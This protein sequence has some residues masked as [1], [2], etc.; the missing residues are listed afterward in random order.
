MTRKL[1][2]AVRPIT[3]PPCNFGSCCERRR[4]YST[5]PSGSNVQ[6]A[7]SV[8]Y[9][10]LRRFLVTDIGDA[11]VTLAVVV[12]TKDLASNQNYQ[13]RLRCI[14]VTES[15]SPDFFGYHGPVWK[16]ILQHASS[17]KT[18]SQTVCVC[19]HGGKHSEQSD[20]HNMCYLPPDTARH[21]RW[22][23]IHHRHA[24]AARGHFL[25]AGKIRF[26]QIKRK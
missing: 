21:H 3:H 13:M 12:R 25:S 23:S 19:L 11:R 16:A 7:S 10:V 6:T 5:L 22:A 20:P 1:R 24:R 14:D 18:S 2:R 9:V 26:G 17:F 15:W 8:K 4:S